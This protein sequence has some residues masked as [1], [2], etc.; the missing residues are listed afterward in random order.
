MKKESQYINLKNE[1]IPI[2]ENITGVDKS[3]FEKFTKEISE[4]ILRRS[5]KLNLG[6]ERITTTDIN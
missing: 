2:W 4:E 6:F 5:V 1:I 3:L